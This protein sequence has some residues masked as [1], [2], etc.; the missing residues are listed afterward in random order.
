MT[1]LLFIVTESPGGGYSARAVGQPVFTQADTDGELERNVREAVLDH[2]DDPEQRPRVLHLHFVRDRTI[3]LQPDAAGLADA[4][5]LRG[6]VTV[7]ADPFEPACD[8][9]DWDANR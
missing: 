6:T 4:F 8:P 5:P 2:F 3:P 7:Y 9:D 1:E